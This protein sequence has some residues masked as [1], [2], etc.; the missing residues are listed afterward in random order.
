M[1]NS[2][3]L[4][5]M[6]HVRLPCPSLSPR[7]CSNSC[8]I[9][10]WCY[11]IILYLVI[12]FSSWLQ[13]FPASGSFPVSWLLASG[14]QS[15]GAS[16]SAPVL[17]MNIQGWFPFGV[18]GL[19]SLQPK[20][21]WRIESFTLQ[22]FVSKVMFLLFNMLS[23]FVIVFLPRSKCLLISC[24]QL[25]SAVI[26]EPKKIKAITV[27]TFPSFI[28]HEVMGPYVMIFFFF[29][30][31]TFKPAFS[32][33]SFT[34]IKRLFS[35]SSLSAIRVVSFAYLRLLIFLPTNLIPACY[36]SSLAFHM[37]CSA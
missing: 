32:F 8:P 29:L 27:S 35:S 31:F 30:M 21:L 22:I 3:W 36:S 25:P 23:R 17:P 6:Q 26:L 7:V 16:A 13:S 14:G 19:I 5:G 28:C 37:M 9:S 18:T 20:R 10:K 34:Y 2:L 11:P 4:H 24:L 1:S 15:T 12:A 33:S